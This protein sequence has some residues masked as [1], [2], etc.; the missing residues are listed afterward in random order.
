MSVP[1]PL[2]TSACHENSG[3]FLFA[4]VR[5]EEETAELPLGPRAT[6]AAQQ[7]LPRNGWL[8]FCARNTRCNPLH[9]M[10]A[11]P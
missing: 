6:P 9:E 10:G 7:L 5:R 8:K 4:V 11:D 3:I 1:D 2:R